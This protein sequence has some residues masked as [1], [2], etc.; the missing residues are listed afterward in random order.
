[1]VK[2]PVHSLAYVAQERF[3][4]PPAKRLPPVGPGGSHLLGHGSVLVGRG[5]G[6]VTQGCHQEADHGH[7]HGCRGARSGTCQSDQGR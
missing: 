6:S 4:T 2:A 3:E 5:Y 7:E 1:M